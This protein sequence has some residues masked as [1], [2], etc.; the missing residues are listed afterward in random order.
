MSSSQGNEFQ[1]EA[2]AEAIGS[3]VIGTSIINFFG[4][5]PYDGGMDLLQIVGI[6]VAGMIPDMMKNKLATRQSQGL[7]MA[8]DYLRDGTVPEQM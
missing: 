2:Q 3:N 6:D 1:T 4:M 5:K 8:V 7:L